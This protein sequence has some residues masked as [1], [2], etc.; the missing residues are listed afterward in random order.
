MKKIFKFLIVVYFALVFPIL[1]FIADFFILNSNPK[2]YRLIPQDADIVIEI[3]TKNF[4]Q[5]VAYQRIFNES[6]F[7]KRLPKDNEDNLVTSDNLDFGINPFSQ[8][9]IFRENWADNNIWYG[10]I[11][12]KNKPK[13][14]TFIKESGYKFNIE[15]A[16][17][18]AIILFKDK[19]NPEIVNHQ[20]KMSQYKLKSFDSK[21]DL[22]EIFNADNELNIYIAPKNSKD[23]IDGYLHFNFEK[24]RVTTSGTFTPV[25]KT[26]DI[27]FINYELNN[28]VALSL[29][30]SLNLF[31]SVYLFN[32]NISL[33]NLP[34][35]SQ[36][37]IDFD[38][39]TLKTLH[40][41]IP[42][43]AYP[44]LNIQFD[45]IDSLNWRNYLNDLNN[46]NT[47]IVDSINHQLIVNAESQSFLNYDLNHQYFKIYQH[48]NN[49][50]KKVINNTFFS[51]IIHP[52]SILEKTFFKKDSLNPPNFVDGIKI[53][54]IESLMDDMNF[55][56]D[57]DYINFTI[58]ADSTST[59][60][61]SRGDVIYLEKEGHSIIE[62]LV[63]FQKFIGSIGAFLE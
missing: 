4:I 15:Y 60:F 53:G 31:N 57:V 7:L 22:S 2:I 17:N 24:D 58:T 9:I 28:D 11:A 38:G 32:K 54:I 16:D 45:I 41:D 40:S 37:C 1:F 43:I 46:N 50:S 62:S 51:L 35:Y 39:T 34:Q 6:Y 56:N 30:S 42:I 23:I 8:V 49:F 47:F 20:Q 48:E 10:I 3:N 18:Y 27:S 14:E 19:N 63:L 61:I 5:E 29:R 21:I 52:N 55:W 12:I 13:F 26:Q 36:L 44:E 25:G 59:D 33:K